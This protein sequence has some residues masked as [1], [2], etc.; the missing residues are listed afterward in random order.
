MGAVLNPKV[1]EIGRARSVRLEDLRVG[2]KLR[3]PVVGYRGNILVHVG[4]ILTQKHLEQLAKWNARPGLGKLSLYTREVDVI[5]TSASGDE[6]PA[7]ET[8]PYKAFLVQRD[9]RKN[10]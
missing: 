9:Y 3:E 2:Y 10:R 8:D 7:V 4:E 6:R 5:N 1:R